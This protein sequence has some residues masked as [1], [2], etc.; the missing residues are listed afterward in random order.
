MG[1]PLYLYGPFSGF[2]SYPVVMNGLKCALSHL[3]LRIID[4]AG[5]AGDFDQ[6]DTRRF[7]LG[8]APASCEPGVF[9]AMKPTLSML[10][11]VTRGY[12]L[13]GMHVGD[14]SAVP[15]EWLQVIR[16][17]DLVVTPS[18]WMQKVIRNSYEKGPRVLVANHGVQ[19]EYFHAETKDPPS[20]SFRFLH[21]CSSGIYPERKGTPQVLRAFQNV[22]D[23]GYGAELTLVVAEVKRPLRR[24]LG[25][26]P[27]ACRGRVNVFRRPHGIAVEEMIDLYQAHHCLLCPSR[28]EGFGIQPLESRAL[29]VPV[30]Q[31][32][33]TGMADHLPSSGSV[34]EVPAVEMQPAWGEF[35]EAPG[36][37]GRDVADAMGVMMETFDEVLQH[38]RDERELIHQ[39]CSW[40]VASE[41]LVREMEKR[42]C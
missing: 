14:V 16:H 19:E 10:P 40:K 39:K 24:L 15:E 26:L 18:A 31:T 4:I 17:E 8:D 35:G 38:A 33:V 21:F 2:S 9:F 28:A 5:P 1:K 42:T 6:R 36:V 41:T 3:D 23:A 32:R 29:G 11:L 22:L 12:S 34:V 20:G 37:R 27:H 7:S 13:V 25:G 30:I